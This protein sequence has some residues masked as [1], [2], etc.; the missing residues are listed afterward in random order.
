MP[1]SQGRPTGDK[2]REILHQRVTREG[3]IFLGN[4]LRRGK[5][6]EG[7]K[8]PGVAQKG[9]WGGGRRL[10]AKTDLDLKG[11]GRLDRIA[12]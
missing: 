3:D 1:R 9:V 10:E 4:F 7:R 8:A 11:G 6:I 5:G 2:K 12:N